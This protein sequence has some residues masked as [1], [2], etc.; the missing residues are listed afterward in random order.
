MADE[1]V[2]GELGGRGMRNELPRDKR[3]GVSAVLLLLECMFPVRVLELEV[4]DAPW[5]AEA[6][7]EGEAVPAGM[8]E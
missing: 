3:V 1:L 7:E 6:D 5:G 4:A 8:A 2:E